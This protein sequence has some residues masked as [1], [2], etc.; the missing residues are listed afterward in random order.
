[1]SDCRAGFKVASSVSFHIE[2]SFRLVEA[3]GL[4]GHKIGDF[5]NQH[6]PIGVESQAHR[7]KIRVVLFAV[8][9]RYRSACGG[10]ELR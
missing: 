4:P 7:L 3:N 8:L 6:D 2:S 10:S 9:N 1:M 5:P